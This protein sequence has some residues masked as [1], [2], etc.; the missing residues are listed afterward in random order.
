MNVQYSTKV[1]SVVA[2]VTFVVHPAERV[3]PVTVLRED[4]GIGESFGALLDLVLSASVV[5]PRRPLIVP[6][7]PEMVGGGGGGGRRRPQAK[8]EGL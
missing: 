8:R 7:G 4:G 5:G 1:K 2:T 3:V 6:V